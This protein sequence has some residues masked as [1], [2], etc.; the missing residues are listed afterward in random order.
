[1]NIA[2]RF[3][4]FRE[5]CASASEINNIEHQHGDALLTDVKNDQILRRILTA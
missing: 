2:N 4:L 5:F 3:K 1:M